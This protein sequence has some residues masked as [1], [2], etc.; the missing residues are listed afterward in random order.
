[1][2]K[3]LPLLCSFIV[4][5]LL[6][7][8]GAYADTTNIQTVLFRLQSVSGTGCPGSYTGYSYMTNNVGTM[9]L[10]PPT[11]TVSGT[12]TDISGYAAPYL[13]V[14]CVTRKSGLLKWCD[15]NSV[16]FPATNSTSYELYVRVKSAALTNGTP[17]TLQI[18]WH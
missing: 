7:G 5:L 11:N 1:M 14:A 17:M 9:W 16:T 8:R 4:L 13:S 12:L 18:V 2:K 10:A 15:T 6:A 3:N